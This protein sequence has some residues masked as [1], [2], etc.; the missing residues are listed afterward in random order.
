LTRGSIVEAKLSRFSALVEEIARPLGLVGFESGKV[1]LEIERSLTLLTE[2]GPS[3][4]IIDVGS[5][6]G[7]PGIPLAIVLGGT[8]LIEPRRRA[9]G[10]L[11]RVVREL[12]LDA[13]VVVSTAQDAARG[14]LRESADVV[15]ARAVA[16]VPV[17]AEWCAPLCRVGGRVILTTTPGYEAE[18]G[19]PDPALPEDLGLSPPKTGILG[20]SLEIQQRVL[21][22]TKE[23]STSPSYPRASRR[24]GIDR[25]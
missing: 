13:A 1:D 17:A 4:Q 19:P 10:F 9:A 2:I 8:T 15:T 7:F 5:G 14:Q 22:M 23:G 20:I 6:A 21:I 25:R 3:N 18:S 12:G 16:P 24:K 11:E